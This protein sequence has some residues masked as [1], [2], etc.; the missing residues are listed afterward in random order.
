MWITNDEVSVFIDSYNETRRDRWQGTK[1][2]CE[3]RFQ[4]KREGNFCILCEKR[5]PYRHLGPGNELQVITSVRAMREHLVSNKRVNSKS[6]RCD[7]LLL[8]KGSEFS[9]SVECTRMLQG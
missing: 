1:Q 7:H 4:G 9:K 2:S 5:D 6:S 8:P 3:G